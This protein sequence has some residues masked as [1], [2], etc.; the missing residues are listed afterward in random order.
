LP[1]EAEQPRGR[2]DSQNHS[3]QEHQRMPECKG[4][5]ELVEH[6]SQKVPI[7]RLDASG[8]ANL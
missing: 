6:S 5:S 7:E 2:E 1:R 8:L 4:F 3:Y